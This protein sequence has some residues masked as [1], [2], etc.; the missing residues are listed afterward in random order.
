MESLLV[1]LLLKLCCCVMAVDPGNKIADKPLFR[2]PLYDDA[3]DP[4]VIWNSKENKW[5][6]FYTDFRTVVFEAGSNSGLTGG[7]EGVHG[8]RIG[9][10]ESTGGGATWRMYYNNEVDGKSIYY[11][12]SPDLYRWTYSGKK[13]VGDKAG[14]GPKCFWVER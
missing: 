12:D 8:T 11:A 3:A 6:M 14:E 10:A 4:T 1:I 5:F 9:I 7:V 2:D 13:A